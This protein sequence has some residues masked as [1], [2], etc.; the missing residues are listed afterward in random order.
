MQ[1]NSSESEI[2]IIHPVRNDPPLM[3][4]FSQWDHYLSS[5]HGSNTPTQTAREQFSSESNVSQH[6]YHRVKRFPSIRSKDFTSRQEYSPLPNDDKKEGLKKK[7]HVFSRLIF[8]RGFMKRAS[9]KR[10]RSGI[11]PYRP[12]FRNLNEFNSCLKYIDLP[13]MINEEYMEERDDSISK[14]ITAI[15]FPEKQPNSIIPE[16]NVMFYKPSNDKGDIVVNKVIPRDIY[17]NYKHPAAI[18]RR[19]TRR[20][21]LSI[22]K[23]ASVR[24]PRRSNTLPA[25]IHS[26]SINNEP[27]VTGLWSQYLQAVITQRIAL[28]LTLMNSQP[29]STTTSCSNTQTSLHSQE[30]ILKNY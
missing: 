23:Q 1:S 22:K 2:Q 27:T 21:Q 9:L 20:K 10:Q 12:K 4:Q 26:T 30:K 13:S 15:M 11:R 5:S 25:T 6:I 29:Q 7:R 18:K 3:A 19:L 8:H 24:I 14:D 17:L 28:R 16:G